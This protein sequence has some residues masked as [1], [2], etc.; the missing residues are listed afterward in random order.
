[1]KNSACAL[2]IYDVI[3]SASERATVEGVQDRARD[4]QE[5]YLRSLE[6]SNR[7]HSASI[8]SKKV[9][10]VKQKTSI[11]FRE[12]QKEV[13]KR[14]DERGLPELKSKSQDYLAKKLNDPT[15]R[16]ILGGNEIRILDEICNEILK[17]KPA[18]DWR[19]LLFSSPIEKLGL[20]FPNAD[21]P[22]LPDVEDDHEAGILIPDADIN[23]DFEKMLSALR[24]AISHAKN[25]QAG[26]LYGKKT[27]S[28][29]WGYV[30]ARTHQLGEMGRFGH[31]EFVHVVENVNVRDGIAW[32]LEKE[33]DLPCRHRQIRKVGQEGEIDKIDAINGTSERPRLAMADNERKRF[34]A[35]RRNSLAAPAAKNIDKK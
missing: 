33:L 17:K 32:L 8:A 7:A 11:S 15:G 29:N 23:N 9:E 16:G 12:L 1:M 3:Y 35:I 14:L 21:E 30:Q 26:I 13:E 28:F 18:M 25:L 2:H 6:K 10:L 34:E 20:A 4:E 24:V 27:A 31:R 19:G 5:N 22:E